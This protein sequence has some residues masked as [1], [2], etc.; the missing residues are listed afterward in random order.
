MQRCRR[1]SAWRG[2]TD[3]PP[4]TEFGGDLEHGAELARARRRPLLLLELSEGALQELEGRR[5]AGGADRR[6]VATV[7][8]TAP[9]PLLLG[10][11]G[12]SGEVAAW[13]CEARVAK[14]CDETGAEAPQNGG[15]R[16][17]ARIA[18]PTDRCL[19]E[20]VVEWLTWLGG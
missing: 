16:G 5:S 17:G 15:R 12:E 3:S 8:S 14:A 4:P 18:A 11:Q 6:P 10:V 1:A 9:K 7:W 20:T 13:E 2:G 19:C